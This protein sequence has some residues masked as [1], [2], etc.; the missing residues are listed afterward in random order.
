M[1][2]NGRLSAW[3]SD[4]VEEVLV[5]VVSVEEVM[6]LLVVVAVDMVLL[7]K[8]VVV[9][10]GSVAL[11]VYVLVPVEEVVVVL[12]AVLPPSE[13]RGESTEFRRNS[14]SGKVGYGYNQKQRH[15][16]GVAKNR[17]AKKNGTSKI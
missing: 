6:V 3:V 10:L 17:N 12:V 9:E 15:Y 5:C 4:R 8:L 14:K 13:S 11:V 16:G 2:H 1:L 7:V